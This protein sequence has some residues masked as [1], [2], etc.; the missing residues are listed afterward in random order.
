MSRGLGFP[1]FFCVSATCPLIGPYAPTVSFSFA[2]S[3]PISKSFPTQQ[4][5]RKQIRRGLPARAG[6]KTG[7]L[8][9]PFMLRRLQTASWSHIPQLLNR[10]PPLTPAPTQSAFKSLSLKVFG[11]VQTP[12]VLAAWTP[13][14]GNATPH[15]PSPQPDV[16]RSGLLCMGRL[17]QAKIRNIQRLKWKLGDYLNWGRKKELMILS[18]YLWFR[19][20]KMGRK[21]S[22]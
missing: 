18:S 20:N 9:G 11:G 4:L 13:L 7:N 22:S 1:C 14:L 6:F 2:L 16:S 8:Y 19:K 21:S 5:L 10:Y 12:E 15:F 3:H 17:T